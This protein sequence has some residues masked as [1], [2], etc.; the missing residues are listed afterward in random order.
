MYAG[1]RSVAKS[2][3]VPPRSAVA[4]DDNGDRTKNGTTAKK[5]DPRKRSRITAEAEDLA[6]IKELR[7]NGSKLTTSTTTSKS[8]T[9]YAQEN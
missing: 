6:K 8:K 2:R 9:V 3:T 1:F 5:Q 7:K 4:T